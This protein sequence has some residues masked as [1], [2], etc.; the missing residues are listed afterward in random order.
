MAVAL[1]PVAASCG[2]HSSATTHAGGSS[3]PVVLTVVGS[4]GSRQFTMADLKA[5][6]AYTGWAGI[7]TSVGTIHLP[8]RYT[9]VKLSDLAAAVGGIGSSNKATMIGSDG[10]GMT[11]SYKQLMQ[12]GLT[13]YDPATGS[14]E[15]PSEPLTAVVAYAIDGKPLPV[16]EE[17]RLKLVIATSKP[18]QVTDG[19]WAVKWLARVEIGAASSE[20][21]L[22][23]QGAVTTTIDKA[24][25]VNCASPGCHGASYT[26]SAG[27]LWEG[28]P[29]WLIAGRADDK[30]Q[31]GAGAF[32][33][34]LAKK[35]AYSL[36]IQGAGGKS[37]T[38]PSRLVTSQ[39]GIIVAYK[40]G[41]KELP[42]A[43]YPLRL[44]GPGLSEAQSVGRML[45]IRLRF[46]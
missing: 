6:P 4:K 21:S 16:Q 28:V 5:M 13:A 12:S 31:H 14:E 24:A 25:Y 40:V 42:A 41:G 8:Q 10:Y 38:L 20:W 9:G 32:N 29:L 33:V 37:V 7:K 39:R 35:G 26:D 3:G 1:A 17:G 43:F 11:F 44:V 2:G 27:K 36:E 15:K 22:P 45:K 30:N 19:H 18:D 46:K 23:L 34:A